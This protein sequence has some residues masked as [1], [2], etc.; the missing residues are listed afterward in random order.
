M[1]LKS[2]NN[3][4][5][6]TFLEVTKYD[7]LS[8]FLKYD[9]AKLSL[10]D[11]YIEYKASNVCTYKD[12]VVRV[13]IGLDN[14]F[15]DKYNDVNTFSLTMIVNKYNKLSETFVPNDLVDV[16][17]DLILG[18]GKEKANKTVI[19][20]FKKMATDLHNETT[21]KILFFN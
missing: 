3:S 13:N 9:Y 10:L 4:T 1:V 2:G 15:Y 17:S 8:D 20:A 19:E 16:P 12:A 21:K 6:K 11:R 18:K 14:E 5:I 7:K